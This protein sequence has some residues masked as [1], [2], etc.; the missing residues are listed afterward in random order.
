MGSRNIEEMLEEFL[1]VWPGEDH[2]DLPLP[3]I[4]GFDRLVDAGDKYQLRQLVKWIEPQ[5]TC[6]YIL[7]HHGADGLKRVLRGIATAC[8]KHNVYM[9][10]RVGNMAASMGLP[11]L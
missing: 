3:N 11:V 6:S 1:C 7:R 10:S 2:Q 8:S 9:G 5:T 4:A